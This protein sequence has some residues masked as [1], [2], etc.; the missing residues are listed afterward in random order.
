[1]DQE[2]LVLRAPRGGT[3]L[4]PPGQPRQPAEWRAKRLPSWEGTPLDAGNRGAFLDVGT[5]VC[6]VGDAEKMEAMLVIEQ[7]SVPFVQAGQAV[8]IR[9]E[10]APMAFIDGTITE[11]A[12][13]DVENMPESL[14]R[15]LDL[16]IQ[17]SGG[18]KTR[19]A[20]TYYQARVELTGH[21]VPLLVGMHGHARILAD[22]QP[23][24]T[25]FWRY[26]QRTFRFS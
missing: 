1:V 8:W 6:L 4:P 13:A 20:E 24:G 15:A 23:L 25:R 18:T 22:W 26:V 10:Q 7:A 16:P 12:K 21:D 19:A 2:R 14:M 11:L 17:G 9:V 3:V 5:L